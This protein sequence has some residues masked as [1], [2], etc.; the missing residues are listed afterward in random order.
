MVRRPWRQTKSPVWWTFAFGCYSLL[1]GASQLAAALP[2]SDHTLKWV[3]LLAG[4][5]VMLAGL[6]VMLG[7]VAQLWAGVMLRRQRRTELLQ[8]VATVVSALERHRR[9]ESGPDQG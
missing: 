5:V 1:F 6:V 9:A 4:L 7:G 2:G 8:A 3:R